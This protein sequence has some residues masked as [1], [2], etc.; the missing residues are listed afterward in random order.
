MA[1]RVWQQ[2]LDNASSDPTSVLTNAR[3]FEWFRKALLTGYAG[4][5]TPITAGLWTV[6]YSCDGVTAGTPGD[7][8]DRW[9]TAYDGSK[10]IWHASTAR[11]WMVLRSPAGF[12]GNGPYYMIIHLNKTSPSEHQG[13]EIVWSKAAPTGGTTTARPTATDETVTI[14]SQ[15]VENAIGNWRF[16]GWVSDQGEFVICSSKNTVG[17]MWGGLW[18][19]APATPITGQTWR[20][21]GGAAYSA[22]SGGCFVSGTF[23]NGSSYWRARNANNSAAATMTPLIL[24]AAGSGAEVLSTLPAGGDY[25]T[26]PLMPTYKTLMWCSTSGYLGSNGYLPDFFW[27]PS[28]MAPCGVPASGAPYVGVLLGSVLFPLTAIPSM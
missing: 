28:A 17:Y 20:L 9:G 19:F 5:T 15:G 18:A 27:G 16:H 13:A 1:D 12:G 23:A 7:A 6:Y 14:N 2:C 24:A 25:F 8:V 3:S 11:S 26:N 4:L 10:L 22:T 21:F